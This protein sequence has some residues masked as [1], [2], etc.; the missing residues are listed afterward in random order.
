MAKFALFDYDNSLS[1]IGSDT[2]VTKLSGY[3][4]IRLLDGVA[5]MNAFLRKMYEVRLTTEEHPLIGPMQIRVLQQKSGEKLD[6]IV[7]DTITH[8]FRRDLRILEAK[9][10]SGAMEMADWGKIE[11][12]YNEFIS[13]LTKLPV[14]VIVNAHTS[15][16][17]DQASGMF[18]FQPGVKGSTKESLPEYFDC[19]FYTKMAKDKKLYTWQTYADFSRFGKDRASLL[20]P[21]IPQDFGSVINKYRAAG[22]P[23]PKILVIGESGTGKTR[24]LITLN[25]I[26]DNV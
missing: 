7:V 17:K 18:Y 12:L 1:T 5:E 8:C 26:K 24:A 10:K 20:E 13:F 11:R 3:P 14:W 19:V 16:D 23:N 9:N 6:G 15:Y 25:N 21:V 2:D 4:P 22:I